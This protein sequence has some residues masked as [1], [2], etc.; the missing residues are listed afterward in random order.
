M[1]DFYDVLRTAMA[2]I[3]APTAEE[4]A[5]VYA[6]VRAAV[7]AQL[8]SRQPP[9]GDDEIAAE[10]ARFEDAVARLEAELAPPP[11]HRE[12]SLTVRGGRRRIDIL[13]EAHAARRRATAAA[14]ALAGAEPIPAPPPAWPPPDEPV[15]DDGYDGGFAE[16]PADEADAWR[17]P[18]EDAGALAG[19]EEDFAE[20]AIGGEAGYGEADPGEGDPGDGTPDDTT[21]DDTTPDDTTP[22]DT[23]DRS[24]DY[25]PPAYVPRWNDPVVADEAAPSVV[26]GNP[27]IE[28]TWDEVAEQWHDADPPPL[29]LADPELTDP[30]LADPDLA[31]AGA[32]APVRRLGAP[33]PPEPDAEGLPDDWAARLSAALADDGVVLAPHSEEP[34]PPPTDAWPQA[35]AQPEMEAWPDLA[36]ESRQ[37]P[38]P[39]RKL[40]ARLLRRRAA[41]AEPAAAPEPEPAPM[42]PETYDSAVGTFAEASAF[43]DD[44]HFDEVQ[45]APPRGDSRQL[46]AVKVRRRGGAAAEPAPDVPPPR[47]AAAPQR[48]G[49]RQR[50]AA[51]DDFGAAPPRRAKER[52]RERAEGRTRGR[53]GRVMAIGLAAATVAVLG[54]SATVFLPLVLPAGTGP[55]GEPAA[56]AAEPVQVLPARQ[57]RAVLPQAAGSDVAQSIL[58]FDGE[59]PTVFESG[60]DNPVRFQGTDG[61]GI[62]RIT[63]SASAGGVRAIIGPGLAQRL[64]GHRIR[65]VLEARASPDNGA[66]SMRLAYQRG[67]SVS[68]W[69]QTRLPAEFT[70]LQLEW[71]VPDGSGGRGSDYLLIE[72]GIPGDNTATDIKSIRIEILS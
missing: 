64:S 10:T 29:A 43:L 23:W 62:A 15:P 40:R 25:H 55:A 66:T 48:S 49:R 51:D 35:E 13:A 31:V 19:E 69:Q 56:A 36:G 11:L 32:Q 41:P 47:R 18:D 68:D 67:R 59:N 3:D 71:D 26:W 12:T 9:L 14:V 50:A 34:E 53:A 30:N 21:P 6:H 52:T 46:F 22:D 70:P 16:A 72:P 8:S 60:P 58:L 28:M 20:A 42:A 4:R 17:A 57:V 45:A 2:R 27:S 39:V 63:S 38:A 61:A 1:T 54:W 24:Y 44:S 7:L 37:P 33:R 65:L 5:R